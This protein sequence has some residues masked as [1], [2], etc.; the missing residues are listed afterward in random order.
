VSSDVAG[1]LALALDPALL[2]TRALGVAP[3]PWQVR[4]LTSTAP[5]V[6]LNIT[7]QGGKSTASAVLA[8]HTALYDPGALVLL[9]APTLRQSSE[10]FK[11]CLQVYRS[12]DRPIPAES[13]TALTLTLDNGSR[14]VS[15]PGAE[16]SIRGYSGV[17]LLIL[18]EAARVPDDLYFSVRPM[19][20]VSSGRLLALSTP[21][22]KRGFF[23]QEWTSAS[24][25]ERYEVPAAQYPRIPAAFL[26]EERASMSPWFFQQEY[27]CV[28]GETVDQVFAYDLVQTALTSD[29]KPFFMSR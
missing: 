3:D 26:E 16:G 10:L 6:L 8:V 12:L 13:E 25:W 4:F 2:M 29:V 22:G 20:A 11:K 5:R 28:F 19:L 9:A 21:F 1:D 27:N 23:H 15:L 24:G 7:R 14:I 18:D 17:R